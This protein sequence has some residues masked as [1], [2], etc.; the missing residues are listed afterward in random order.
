MYRIPFVMDKF[1]DSED[2]FQKEMAIIY[3]KVNLPPL[4]T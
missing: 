3:S 2:I 4:K 1:K